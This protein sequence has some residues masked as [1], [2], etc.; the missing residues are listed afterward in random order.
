MSHRLLLPVIALLAIACSTSYQF[1]LQ[2]DGTPLPP[3]YANTDHW[4]ALP[5]KSDPADL[6]P[7][8]TIRDNQAIAPADVFFLHPTIYSNKRKEGQPW[9]GAIDDPKLNRKVD[10]STI[11]YQ[12]SVFNGAGR[13]Y[14]PRYRQ[15][16]LSAYWLKDKE[17]QKQIFDLAYRDVKAAFEY[18]LQHYNQGRPIIIASHS[19]GTTHAKRLVREF[20]DGKPLQ[21]QLVAAYLVGIVVE[22]DYFKTLRPCSASDDTGCF[23]SW[24]AYRRGYFPRNHQSGSNIV[25]TNPL[26]WTSDTTLAPK[27]LN[28]GSVLRKFNKIYPQ[29]AE[30]QVHDGLLWLDRPRFPGS[31]LLRNP[32]YHIADYNFYYLNVRNNAIKRVQA[33]LGGSAQ[34]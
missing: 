16:H 24:R 25:V 26:T 4:A 29:I 14:A 22:G 3:D 21:R 18:Y 32:N 5:S 11:K 10:D 9:N 34:K 19:Q 2:N 23:V 30:A 31:F 7:V 8:D 15:A 17:Q 28:Q 12:A 13:V 20:F 1:Q 27:T 33:F 6:T